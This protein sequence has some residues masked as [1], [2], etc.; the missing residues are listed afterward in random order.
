VEKQR[1]YEERRE[2]VEIYNNLAEPLKKQ[3]LTIARV[4]DTTQ[5]ITLTEKGKKKFVKKI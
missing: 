3:L 4:I 5:E 1:K 2:L